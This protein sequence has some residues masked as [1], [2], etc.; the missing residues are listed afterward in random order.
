MNT[1]N[2][3]RFQETDEKIQNCFLT[4]L[5][6]KQI[7]RITVQEICNIIGI[8]R[9]SFYAHYEDIYALLNAISKKVGRD[10]I[11]ELKKLEYDSSIPIS[12]GHLCITLEHIKTYS[13]FYKG[14]LSDVGAAKTEEHFRTL[15]ESIFRPWFQQHL[16]II[17]DHRIEYHFSFFKAGLMAI[18]EQWLH[19]DCEEPSEEIAQI[20]LDSIRE[21]V[22]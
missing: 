11:I 14:W 8:N 13:S 18:I 12:K 16:G 20:I 10:L 5:T 15:L 6:Q 2:N 3:L 9:S 7:S 22:K 17:S 1:K 4:L 21:P 19:Y